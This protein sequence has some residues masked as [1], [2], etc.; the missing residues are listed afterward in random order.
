MNPFKTATI[1]LTG[2]FFALPVAAQPGEH[3]R[4]NKTEAPAGLAK[5]EAGKAKA[6][7]AKAKA[8]ALKAKAKAKAKG[9]GEA[10]ATPR[11]GGERE[12]KARPRKGGERE[13]KR[14]MSSALQQ[15][16]RRHA[17][18]TARLARIRSIAVD[19]GNST[20]VSRADSLLAKE[21][22][23]HG[24]WMKTYDARKVH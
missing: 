15:E 22:A 18:R 7:E 4:S 19:K 14:P 10:K 13:A 20:V 9:E 1:V 2:L 12:A 16:T 5:S 21:N 23:R 17:S 8:T 24:R 3:R 6:A 11:K